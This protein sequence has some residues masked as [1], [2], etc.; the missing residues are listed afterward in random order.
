MERSNFDRLLDD[1]DAGLDLLA[2][3]RGRV[4]VPGLTSRGPGRPADFGKAF[5]GFDGPEMVADL[6]RGVADSRRR[7]ASYRRMTADLRA[8]T[9]KAECAS[10]E[11]RAAAEAS[12]RGRL[13]TGMHEV[14]AKAMGLFREGAITGDQIRTLEAR[15]LLIDRALSL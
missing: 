11:T 3:Q 14:M 10:A 5:G 1:V 9:R 15:V 12:R 4:H 7:T 2:H 13:R 8:L 6:R